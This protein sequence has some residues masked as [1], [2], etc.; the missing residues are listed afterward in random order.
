MSKGAPSTSGEGNIEGAR[1]RREVSGNQLLVGVVLFLTAAFNLSFFGELAQAYSLAASNALPLLTVPVVLAGSTLLLLSPFCFGVLTRPALAL[2]LIASAAAAGFMDSYGVIIN[3]EMLRNAVQTQTAEVLDLLTPRLLAYL[4]GLGV[5]PAFI[6][7]RLTVRWQGWRAELLARFKLLAIAFAMVLGPAAVFGGFYS[8]L[9]REHK[10]LRE[11]VNPTYYLYSLGKF[12]RAQEV[13]AEAVAAIG[14]DAHHRAGGH[15]RELV[16]LVIGEAARAD[17]FSLNGYARETNPRLQKEKNLISFSNFWSCGTSTAVSVP[18]MFS[19]LGTAG[20]NDRLARQEENV[21]DIVQRTG[22][23]VWWLDNNSSSKGVAERVPY[24][25]FRDPKVNPQCDVECRDEGMLARLQE[26]VDSRAD[27]DILV[28]L[29][30]MGN[31]GPAYYKRYPDAFERFTP[32]CKDNDLNRCSNEEI[33]NA[34]DNAILYTDHFLGK[35]IDFLKHNDGPGKFA[36]A[37]LYLSDHGE[38]LGEGGTYLH[39]LPRALAPDTQIHI[40]AVMWFG[41]HF[42]EIDRA[43]VN[44][45]RAERFSHDHLFHTLLGLMAIETREY[46][47]ELDILN[48][49]R[50]AAAR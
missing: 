13:G 3:D 24:L 37:L 41:D 45:R 38:S 22:D 14:A 29:H 18:C 31:H 11:F 23:F 10:D 21:L 33:G 26:V 39:G 1:L 7:M 5:L 16:I 12:L 6:V 8:T 40:P 35:V 4:L 19:R 48:G 17:R 34:Y 9:A 50:K 27:G 25:N 20:Y 15:R 49:L 46:R 42:D 28:V 36:S 44:E 43:A 30:Q 47:A 32:T 2:I